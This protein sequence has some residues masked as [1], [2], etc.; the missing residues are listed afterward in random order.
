MDKKIWLLSFCVV[1]LF[2]APLVT[3]A[4]NLQSNLQ[5]NKQQQIEAENELSVVKEQ[6][7]QVQEEIKAATE[8]ITELNEQITKLNGSIQ[9]KETELN[10]IENEIERL[11]KEDQRIT[12]LLNSREEEFKERVSSYYRTEGQMSF[13]D[14]IF[15][16]NSF[17]EFIDQTVSYSTIVNEDKRF[18]EEYVGDQ[19]NVSDIKDQVEKLKESTIQEK[20]ELE[21]IKVSQEKNKKEKEKLSSFL[22]EKKLQLEK[23]E[24][25]KET[26]L[27]L[28]KENGETIQ[29]VVDLIN[30]SN[31]GSGDSGSSQIIKSVVAPFVADAQKLQQ[32]KGIP[33]SIILGQ[34]ILESSGRYNGLS[35]LAYEAKNLF[36]VKGTGTAGSVDMNT[37]EYVNG[38]KII[39]KEKFA[40]YETYYDSMAAHSNL[41][42]KP[43]YQKYLESAA[44]IEEYARGIHQAGYATD[45][46][47]AT[48]LIGIIDRYGLGSFD[49]PLVS[50][51][52]EK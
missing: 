17:G 12:V 2:A 42:L 14:V 6:K 8:K 31:S 50:S 52:R 7:L 46:N 11:N 10:E 47:Y 36:G 44:S 38:K 34:I 16:A 23:E 15:S 20:K 26:A 5:D 27:K 51:K 32:E 41:L 43:R 30:S 48:I 33:A 28:L 35:G 39:S 21:S 13:L 29:Q 45:P 18:I 19:K 22:V 49:A 4:E 3:S 37:T 25:E 9:K 24:L 40:K 1:S